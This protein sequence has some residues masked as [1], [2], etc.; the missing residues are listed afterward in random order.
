MLPHGHKGQVEPHIA[1]GRVAP[2]DS[3]EGKERCGQQDGVSAKA[4]R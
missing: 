4:N 1:K 3:S 2:E